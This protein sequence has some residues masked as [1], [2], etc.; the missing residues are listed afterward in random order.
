MAIGQINAK[1]PY[2]GVTL[3]K[4]P[5]RKSKCPSCGMSIYIKTAPNSK[6]KLLVTQDQAAEIDKQLHEFYE[7]EELFNYLEGHGIARIEFENRKKLN[8][9]VNDYDI[10]WGLLNE[11]IL[12]TP[13]LRN[14]SLIHRTMASILNKEHKS[15]IEALR[16]SHRAN[17]EHM[18]VND[19]KKVKILT[20]KKESCPYCRELEGIILTIYDALKLMPIPHPK[21]THKLYDDNQGWCRCLYT[22]II[23]D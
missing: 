18:K 17:L 19:V 5:E 12:S 8:T 13:D 23:E 1:C 4:R 20:A 21:C 14:V 10:A 16:S 7:R 11:K 15:C 2:C 6:E 3:V 9:K 22:A